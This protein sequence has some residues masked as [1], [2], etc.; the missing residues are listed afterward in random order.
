[1]LAASGWKCDNGFRNGYLV[2]LE[3]H[4]SRTFPNCDLKAKPQISSKMHVWKKQYS[5]LR[6]MFSKSGLGWDESRNMIVV[7]DDNAWDDYVKLDRTAKGMRFKSWSW[8]SA[9]SEIFGKDQAKE[10]E[11]RTPLLMLSR[12][13]RRNNDVM[14]N[15]TL[16]RQSGILKQLMD[17]FSS[18]CETA[19]NCIGA[20][21]RCLQTEFGTPEQR[22]LIL[23]VVHELNEFDENT[24]LK[25]ARRLMIEP[26]EMEL[27]F[28]LSK[29]SRIK[30][31]RMIV[32]ENF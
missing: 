24:H 6:T 10:T 29:E 17:M 19:N 15:V 14:K 32:D 7:E 18:F 16:P 4:M 5:T 25:G 8:Y 27:F 21:T 30:M 12:C 3:A 9:W 28:K 26:K 22:E 2:Q 23:D 11:G 1:M 13:G 20:L 31:V